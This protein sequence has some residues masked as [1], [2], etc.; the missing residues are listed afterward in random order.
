MN[1]LPTTSLLLK[2]QTELFSHILNKKIKAG[3]ILELL[4]IS[5]IG[6]AAFG[7]VMSLSFPHWWH[8]VNLMWKNTSGRIFPSDW[9][10][11]CKR[12]RRL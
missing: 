8:T 3:H 1:L 2:Q 12:A 4:G 7:A 10:R 11:Q 6:L 9:G 5:V